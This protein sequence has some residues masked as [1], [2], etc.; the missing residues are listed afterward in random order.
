MPSR[1]GPA[2]NPR[3]RPGFGAAAT[4][5]L[6]LACFCLAAALAAPARA[7]TV[8]A[9]TGFKV[10]PNGFSFAN[11]GADAGYARLDASQLKRMFGPGVCLAGGDSRCVLGPSARQ[12]MGQIN[13]A[14][15]NGHCYGFAVLAELI[16]RSQLP[17]FGYAAIEAFGGGPDAWDLA[18]EGNRKLQQAIAR[19]WALQTLPSVQRATV[20]GKP[21]RVLDFLRRNLTPEN[22]ESYTLGIFQPGFQGGH[23][24]TPIAVEDMGSG[25][26]EIHVY[27]NNWPGDADRRLRIDTESETWSYYAATRPGEPGAL[28]RGDARTGTLRVMPTRPGLGTQTCTFCVG[29][30]GRNSRF[31]QISISGSADQQASLLITDRQGRQTGFRNGRL[32]NEIPRARVLPQ[33]SAGPEPAADGGL[34]N[35]ADSPQPVFLIPRAA[36]LRIKVNGRPLNRP[37]RA[38]LSVVGPTFDAAIENLRLSPGQ[39]AFA[40][41]SPRRKTLSLTGASRISP[42]ASFGAQTKRASYRVRISTPGAPPRSTFFFA[43]KPRLG[44]LRIA[45][46]SDRRQRYRVSIT[47]FTVKGPARFA[48]GYRIGGKQQAF[49]YYG[50]LVNPD[51]VA[52]IAIGEPGKDRVR[53]LKLRRVPLGGS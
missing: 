49:L 27:D 23:A 28:Y 30:Q 3:R 16:Y 41:L 36:K 47:R 46:K 29:R 35:L 43:K 15:G 12:W 20:A 51:G 45:S 24:I 42:V 21:S 19:A 31:N 48:A 22:R 34:E 6:L 18:I 9:D 37:D 32:V 40:S 13:A 7:G 11:Y 4:L 53:V 39:V 10:N 50:P 5:A 33:T 17:R 25:I 8:V 38:T 26:F 52:R 14:L 2:V 44:L 1:P